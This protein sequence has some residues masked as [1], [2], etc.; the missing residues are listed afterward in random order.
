MV[1]VVGSKCAVPFAR[2]EQL[3]D[4]MVFI[5]MSI[6]K[7]MSLPTIVPE[8]EPGMRPCIPAKF[9]VPVT[10]EPDWVSCHVTAPMPDCPI[11]AP[12]PSVLLESAAV[13]DHVPLTLDVD[14]GGVV[15]VAMP[16][17]DIGVELPHAAEINASSPRTISLIGYSLSQPCPNVM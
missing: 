10:V 5:G 7:V 16:V 2:A 11:I 17:G 15:D 8:N 1:I 9:I 13:P 14:A 12:A 6:V 4:I 3:D